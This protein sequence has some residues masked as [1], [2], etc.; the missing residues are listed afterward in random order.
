MLEYRLLLQEN[1]FDFGVIEARIAWV[2]S[3]TCVLAFRSSLAKLL[4]LACE[5]A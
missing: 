1:F 3:E 4:D 2:V 5:V